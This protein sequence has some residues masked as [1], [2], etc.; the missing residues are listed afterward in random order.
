MSLDRSTLAHISFHP[1]PLERFVHNAKL[2]RS[3]LAGT[4]RF[5]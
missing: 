3:I 5:F 4:G 1:F 2:P